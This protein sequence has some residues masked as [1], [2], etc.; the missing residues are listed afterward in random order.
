MRKVAILFS[1]LPLVAHGMDLGVSGDSIKDF[2]QEARRPL[3]SATVDVKSVI[4]SAE[5]T[6]GMAP[7]I[8]DRRRS[9]IR[10]SAVKPSGPLD[11]AALR[12]AHASNATVI[13]VLPVAALPPADKS[14]IPLGMAQPSAT[15]SSGVVHPYAKRDPK[16]Y[17]SS[18]VVYPPKWLA[19]LNLKQ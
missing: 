16:A 3:L 6:P 5:T 7:Q 10:T 11:V 9:R 17:P 19:G 13:S 4:R 15:G 1:F 8:K 14:S 2:S 12:K 18:G